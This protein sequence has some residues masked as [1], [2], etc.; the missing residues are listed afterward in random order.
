MEG[1]IIKGDFAQT[2][3]YPVSR[4]DYQYAGEDQISSH[5][6]TNAYDFR[7][8][9]AAVPDIEGIRQFLTE[10]QVLDGSEGTY[11]GKDYPGSLSGVSASQS[12]SKYDYSFGEVQSEVLRNHDGADQEIR[13]DGQ[14][15]PEL[16][17][18]DAITMFIDPPQDKPKEAKSIQ[19]WINNLKD[20]GVPIKSQALEFNTMAS[21]VYNQEDFDIYPMGWGGTGPF[22]SSAFSFFHS[23][24]ADDRS[25][26]NSER[27]MYNSTGYG[28]HGGSADDLLKQA[29]EEMNPEERNKLT[30]QALEKIYL[31][32]PYF[33]WD[34]AKVRWPVNSADFQGYVSGLVDPA[35]AS[36]GTV[37]NN[38]HQKQ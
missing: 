26:G 13:V 32:S 29:Q 33:V 8:A 24:M 7:S 12:E 4:P 36:F 5:P 38:I 16:M 6:A 1:Y 9:S 37:L 34:Y 20:L 23:S 18:G 3:G 30:A 19:R 21:K 25:E 2:P 22:G 11:V 15:I 14:T 17:D 10:G 27:F 35:Y 31:D 28:L